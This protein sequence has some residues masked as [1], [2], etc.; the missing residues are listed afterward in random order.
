MEY[1]RTHPIIHHG[2]NI[3]LQSMRCRVSYVHISHPTLKFIPSIRALFFLTAS[4]PKCNLLLFIIVL[5]WNPRSVFASSNHFPT[6]NTC[7]TRPQSVFAIPC[8][9][10]IEQLFSAHNNL[11]HLWKDTLWAL[12]FKKG[13]QFTIRG[14]DI[15][16]THSK[17]SNAM[18]QWT[19]QN[20]LFTYSRKTSTVLR[21]K[22]FVLGCGELEGST[23]FRS[24]TF[25]GGLWPAL[26]DSNL[27][28]LAE[29]RSK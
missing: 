26:F 10:Y 27:T 11:P 5:K 28:R 18:G 25:P 20:A 12:T 21:R 4:W 24:S 13:K 19:D 16:M 14:C 2:P 6:R 22:N 1:L 7:T 15:C 3:S 9:S 17:L 23:P 29:H 8:V